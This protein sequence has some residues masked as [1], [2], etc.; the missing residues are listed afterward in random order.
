MT[1]LVEA[2]VRG[3]GLGAIADARAAGRVPDDAA[4]APLEGCDLLALGA[5]A[6]AARRLE[7]SDE[8]RVWV[9]APPTAAP[10]T[11]VF[12]ASVHDRGTALLRRV[13]YARLAGPLGQRIVLDWSALG[14]EIC[15]VA[16]GFG[17]SDLAGPIASRRGLPLLDADGAKGQIKRREIAGY[18][19]RAGFRPVF[20]TLKPVEALRTA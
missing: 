18:V 15:Q 7:L 6:D 12:D 5:C 4:L 20:V 11:L 8:V 17:A 1:P 19:E 3:A 13:A 10:G 16:L 14:L 9:P 2:L